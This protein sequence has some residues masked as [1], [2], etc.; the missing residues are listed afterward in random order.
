[1]EQN[2]SAPPI[3]TRRHFL[4]W[5]GTAAFGA[6]IPYTARA[7]GARDPRFICIILRGALD[8]LA[9]VPPVG[10]PDFLRLRGAQGRSMGPPLPLD[11]FFALHP[12][13]PHF[14]EQYKAGKG[15]VVHAIAS[16]YRDRSHFDGQDV[17][18]SGFPGPGHTESGWLNR[19]L[20]T[21]PHTQLVKRVQGL[22]IGTTTPLTIRGPANVLGWA[23]SALTLNDPDLPDRIL[24]LYDGS[25]KFLAETL[26]DAIATR[27]ITAGFDAKSARGGPSD[28]DMMFS[29]ATGAAQLMARDDGPRIAALAFE[30]WD[31]HVAETDRLSRLLGGLDNALDTFQK[32]LGPA[33]KDTAILVITEFGRT[34]SINGTQGTDHG[35]GTTAFL[36]GG[37]VRGGRVIADWPGLKSSQLYQARDLA[38]TTD[39]RSVAKGIIAGFYDIP[40][41]VMSSSIFPDSMSAPL[42]KDLIA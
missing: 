34:A 14:A 18:E 41:N 1:L 24:D 7:A 29:M 33:W 12:A 2:A 30:G 5:G 40:E 6:C 37:A 42:I 11:G 36:T 3:L 32:T 25:D 39:I 22:S 10:D 26:R 8:G 20:Q 35:T 17:L 15:L 38:A 21:L 23:P 16:P 28:P 4:Q 13:M 31:T 27:R 19:L 9:A